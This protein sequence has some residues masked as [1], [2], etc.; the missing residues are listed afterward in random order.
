M[1]EHPENFERPAEQRESQGISAQGRSS[2]QGFS[3]GDSALPATP[4]DTP[5]LPDDQFTDNKGRDITART[6][7]SGDSAYIR[8]FDRARTPE[9][10][11]T[12]TFSDV[13]KANLLLKRDEHGEVD[14]AFL[15][16]IEISN[17]EYRG[18]GIG[19][20]VLESA[21]NY[22]KSAKAK[23]IYGVFSPNAGE[24]E[25]LRKWY[26]GHGYSFRPGSNGEEVYKKL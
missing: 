8:A 15:Q 19:S 2:M 3:G 21:E 9:V 11:E 18:S 5:A 20:H 4:K 10:P 14:R 26:Q 16:D 1:S 13:G 7:P 17:K 23:E 24:E 22:S 6:Y 25:D 12:A